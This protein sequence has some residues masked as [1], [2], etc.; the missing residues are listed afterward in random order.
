MGAVDNSVFC[1]N[2][3]IRSAPVRIPTHS[4]TVSTC[5]AERGIRSANTLKRSG[6]S[7]IR[8]DGASMVR[9]RKTRAVAKLFHEKHYSQNVQ[10]EQEEKEQ[11]GSRFP[12]RDQSAH[13]T[14]QSKERQDAVW[15]IVVTQAS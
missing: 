14:P 1:P 10:D 15:C 3:S 7:R 9:V 12:W 11:D 2:S 8:E 5:S 13:R 4:L 6:G